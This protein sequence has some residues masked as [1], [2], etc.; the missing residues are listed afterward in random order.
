MKLGANLILIGQ[1]SCEL[2][3]DYFFNEIHNLWL[4]LKDEWVADK[5]NDFFCVLDFF[6][7]KKK[8]IILEIL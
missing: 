6:K 5:R 3:R 4:F 2:P 1:K 7:F 8:I